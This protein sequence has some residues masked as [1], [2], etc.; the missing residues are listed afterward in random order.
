MVI[1]VLESQKNE[2]A[3]RVA[4]LPLKIKCE[5]VTL[6]EGD[7]GTADAL[8]LM[9]EK[10]HTDVLLLPCDLVTNV[11]FYPMLNMFRMHDASI[12]SLFMKGSEVAS[13]TVVPGPKSKQ[14]L[15]RDLIGLN[16][17]NNRLLFMA[18]ESDLTDTLTL[19]GHLLRSHGKFSIFSGLADAHVYLLKKWVIDYLAKSDTFFSIKELISFI[20]KKQLSR[21]V[22]INTGHSEMN[23]DSNDIFEHVRQSALSQKVLETNLNNF[24]R[25][26]RSNDSELIRCFAYVA[27]KSSFGVR[28]NTVLNFCY[29]NSQIVSLFPSLCG[30][31]NPDATLISKSATI[32]CKQ[33]SDTSVG[34]NTTIEE[35]TSIKSSVIGANCSVLKNSRISNSYIMNNA[36]IGENV[37]IEN[38]IICDKA[39]VKEKAVLKNCIVGHNFV[40]LE[41]TT[42]DKASLTGEETWNL[43]KI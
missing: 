27:P 12:V 28:V 36:K 24:S 42:A 3:Q 33:M 31:N 1:V 4:K 37:Q 11:D 20:I 14:T 29:V 15:E 9:K 19:P 6:S 26:K 18:S 32:N 34:D 8:R 10:I 25:I 40:V 35:R 41:G 5:Y 21:P 39:V 7:N 17:E 16:T 43:M 38:S 22:N 30:E 2:I 13:S 23:F